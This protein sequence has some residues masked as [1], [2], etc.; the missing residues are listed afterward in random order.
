MESWTGV[1]KAVISSTVLDLPEHRRQAIEACLRQ[2]VLPSAMEY[3]PAS[4]ASA[5]RESLRL[6]DEASIYVGIFGHCYGYVPPGHSVS[7]TEMEFDRAVERGMPCLLFVM[8]EDHVA[9]ATKVETGPGAEKLR[10]FKDKI[11]TSYV[12]GEFRSPEDL[13]AL[14]INSLSH[15]RT[16]NPA[17]LH[18]IG[19]IPQPPTPYIAH[20]YTLLSRG[21]LVGRAYELEF[22]T[23]WAAGK[24]SP[25]PVASV[26]SVVAIGG[27]GKSALAW[28]WFND[29]GPNKMSPL[30]G[31]IWW[32]FYESDASFE[33]FVVRALAYV[34]RQDRDRIARISPSEREE[35]LLD[36]FRKHPYLVVLD[37]LERIL[38]AYGR[39]DAA[40][41]R[42]D[43]LDQESSNFV[44]GAA[45][46]QVSERNFQSRHWLRKT[47]DPRAGNFLKKL[48]VDCAAKTLI[49]TRLYPSELQTE[50]GEELPGSRGLFLRGLK[51]QDAIALW[52]R[53]RVSGSREVLIPL[54]QSFENYPLVIRALAGE[55]AQDRRARG[56]FEVWLQH[57]PDLDPA[58]LPLVQRKSHVL[59]FALRGI[60]AESR[61]VLVTLAG[62]RMPADYPTLISL[63]IGPDKTFET[64]EALDAALSD[65]EDR[66]LLGWDR[67]ANRY[68]L[69][70]IVRSVAWSQ[71]GRIGQQLI[72]ENLEIYFSVL[73]S[74]EKDSI[75]SLDDLT[76]AIELYSALIGLHNFDAAWRVF[77]THL[78]HPMLTQLGQCRR[79]AELLEALFPG[80]ME[81]PPM[82]TED[83]VVKATDSLAY[84]YH[85]SGRL[86]RAA[87]LWMRVASLRDESRRGDAGVSLTY[88]G[89]LYSA[90]REAH[91]CLAKLKYLH[92]NIR[93][94][95]Y[96]EYLKGRLS[97]AELLFTNAI[98]GFE[99]DLCA[100]EHDIFA[101]SRAAVNLLAMGKENEAWESAHRAGE[102]ATKRSLERPLCIALHAQGAV[103][104]YRGHLTAAEEVLHDAIRRSRAIDYL[105]AEVD[106]VVELAALYEKTD[107]RRRATELLTDI[108]DSIERGP[109]GLAKARACNLL[110]R[111]CKSEGDTDGARGWALKAFEAAWGEGPP[112]SYASQLKAATNFLAQLGCDLPVWA[113]N[114][115]QL[116]P[117]EKASYYKKIVGKLE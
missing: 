95:A 105:V 4:P 106:A 6:V 54:F 32:S 18:H 85:F 7:I 49:T 57:H 71:L 43:D 96:I 117:V 48:T 23:D 103:H 53:F 34:T 15:L 79:G 20:P 13:R 19:D 65:L 52:R 25:Q 75:Q 69:H 17:S 10:R 93:N 31:R 90:E 81:T 99:R 26:L 66:G 74:P 84:A 16:A 111:L 87:Q 27:M 36:H 102:L 104:L 86:D 114:R 50:T 62:F 8:S 35:R 39:L 91:F 89:R 33:N 28:N 61:K 9:P 78:S 92:H 72:Y 37:G 5:I 60:S 63:L 38:N 101:C 40:R 22:L 113:N 2:G 80:G 116:P 3:L 47:C 107:S 58:A 12:I 88:Q 94:L 115:E 21:D 100:D 41:M 73:P 64:E 44:W 109:F 59:S 76:G 77:E 29:V 30:A 46:F 55:V 1:E 110:A 45:G 83:Q 67:A 70:P 11:R 56:D 24:D 51:N 98:M 112:F 42:E 68:D 14:L 108:M 82:L 97:V